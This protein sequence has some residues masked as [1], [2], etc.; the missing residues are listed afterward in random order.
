[1][2]KT[3]SASLASTSDKGDRLGNLN[4]T[5]NKEAFEFK[6]VKK[7]KIDFCE[8]SALKSDDLVCIQNWIDRLK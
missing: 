7:F 2:R 5:K 3:S 8:C 4:D 1:M 6:N